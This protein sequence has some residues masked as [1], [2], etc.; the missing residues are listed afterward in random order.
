M[1]KEADKKNTQADL[2][3]QFEQELDDF[4]KERAHF[5]A[6]HISDKPKANSAKHRCDDDLP[7]AN[8]SG[9]CMT[10][11]HDCPWGYTLP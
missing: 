4:F 10:G 11:C 7:L 1:S 8:M 2:S 9:C 6:P 3:N 5:R